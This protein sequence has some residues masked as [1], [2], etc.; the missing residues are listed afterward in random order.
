MCTKLSLKQERQYLLAVVHV[1]GTFR[2]MLLTTASNV[3][4]TF[5]TVIKHFFFRR[6]IECNRSVFAHY[7]CT[8]PC[9]YS[10]MIKLLGY[11]V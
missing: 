7:K 10:T 11:T 4:W 5:A 3:G 9:H 1:Q 6:K 2:K 8:H